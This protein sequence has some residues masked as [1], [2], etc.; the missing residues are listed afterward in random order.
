MWLNA[1]QVRA[2]QKAALDSG[3]IF[4]VQRSLLLQGLPPGFRAGLVMDPTPL[5]QFNLDLGKLNSIERLADGLVPLVR[6]L[7]NAGEQL[8]LRSLP[9]AEI[10]KRLANELGNR[11]RGAAVASLPVPST[12]PEIA[13]HEVIVGRDDMV[14]FGFVS[15]ALVAG[16]SVAR[17]LVP[18]FEDDNQIRLANGEPWLSRGTTWII[19]PRLVITNHHVVNARLDGQLDASDAELRLQAQNATVEFDFD[20]ADADKKTFEVE[21]LVRASKILDYAIL[22]LKKD[23]S[24]SAIALSPERLKLTPTSYVAV[25]IIQHPRGEAKQIAFRNNLVT[26][27]DDEQIRYFTDTDFGSSGSPVCDDNW[28]VVALHRGAKYAS[29][30]SYQG[31]DTAYVNF[32]SQIQAIMADVKCVN[33]SLYQEIVGA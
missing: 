19:G 12:L 21:S 20:R 13:K 26:A 7:Q 29:G 4:D 33:A 32:G 3:L 27:T 11:V 10:F 17:I 15:R 31:K 23:P 18:R 30:V 24:R 28:R 25:N 9:Q 8:E 5:N 16:G 6:Y 22:R 2:V 14:D 1:E